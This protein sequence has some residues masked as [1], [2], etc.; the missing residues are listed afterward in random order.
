M[1]QPAAF[2][3]IGTPRVLREATPGHTGRTRAAEIL[4][5]DLDLSIAPGQNGG[6]RLTP[7]PNAGGCLV[8]SP[9][10]DNQ[11]DAPPSAISSPHLFPLLPYLFLTLHQQQS[12]SSPLCRTA[13]QFIQ[14]PKALQHSTYPPTSRT[15]P[16]HHPL[17]ILSETLVGRYSPSHPPRP[18]SQG[19]PRNS[20]LCQSKISRPTVREFDSEIPSSTCWRPRG[21]EAMTA[22]APALPAS[23]C[24]AFF[25]LSANIML[26]CS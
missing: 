2:Q 4:C 16:L 26:M 14:E 1:T 7:L 6:A 19:H 25:P 10:M 5:D 11:S 12:S 3:L 17:R 13:L 24:T 23:P 22:L 21:C 9:L 20:S 18:L 8:A 15:S